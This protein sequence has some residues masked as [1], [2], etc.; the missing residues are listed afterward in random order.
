MPRTVEEA[1]KWL[2]RKERTAV[3]NDLELIARVASLPTGGGGSR[4]R[5]GVMGPR[6]PE[7]PARACRR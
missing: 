5:A 3:L 7:R 1:Q 2:N 4:E 6:R